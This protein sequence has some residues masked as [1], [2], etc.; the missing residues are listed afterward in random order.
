MP[1]RFAGRRAVVTGAS[2]GM[3]RAVARLFAAEGAR[4][5]AVGRDPAKL[6]AVAEGNAGVI[7]CAQD[8]AEPDAPARIVDEAVRAL[9][10]I[11]IL[12][13]C[14][15]LFTMAPVPEVTAA[16]L[17]EMMAVN[18]RAPAML[19]VLAVPYL[20][21]SPAGRIV[22]ISS[23]A[24]RYADAAMGG[25]AASKCALEGF[26]M[27]LALELGPLGITANL[28]S[29][30]M[31]RTGMTEGLLQDP[32]VLGYFTGRVP[33]GRVGSAE[34]VAEAVAYLAG[35]QA[36]FATGTTIRLDGGYTVGA[37]G[38]GWSQ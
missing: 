12:V 19:C 3:G 20:R 33:A 38:S 18:F 4:V 1:E 31:T 10:G 9:G 13:N 14:A 25:Y 15:A 30:G 26:T 8:L 22:N 6:A 28:V 37:H 7:P 11:D 27:N 29:P 2:D 5:L 21:E 17:D 23:I 34:E 24:T 16:H 32:K 35:G 36:G